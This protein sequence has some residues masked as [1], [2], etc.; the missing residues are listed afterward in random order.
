M[1]PL[2]T[3]TSTNVHII[4][5]LVIS[6]PRHLNF[7]LKPHKGQ[8]VCWMKW[9]LTQMYVVDAFLILYRA[10]FVLPSFFFFSMAPFLGLIECGL[11]AIWIHEYCWMHPFPEGEKLN[12]SLWSWVWRGFFWWWWGTKNYGVSLPKR[13]FSFWDHD[14]VKIF[15]GRLLQDIPPSM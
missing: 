7:F 4:C 9:T 1:R 3:L 14:T 2:Q 11:L 15:C 10:R 13:P 8:N 6:E 12:T 5:L